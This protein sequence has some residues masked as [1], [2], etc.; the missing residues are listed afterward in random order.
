VLVTRLSRFEINWN[1]RVSQAGLMKQIEAHFDGEELDDLIF[2]LNIGEGV[3][4]GTDAPS[5]GKAFGGTCGA[6]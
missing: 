4:G 5:A 6:A 3:I 1:G 2:T